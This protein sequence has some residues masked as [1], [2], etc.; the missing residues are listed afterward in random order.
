MRVRRWRRY[1]AD[2]AFVVDACG[3][4]L[5]S[6]DLT[7]G[8]VD[9]VEPE[10]DGQVRRAVQA[11]LRA[12]SDEVVVPQQH[13]SVEGLS[14]ADEQLL[15][16]WLGAPIMLG[17]PGHQSVR[18]VRSQLERLG[19]R[20][21]AV[22]HQVPLGRQG[23]SCPH[24]LVG[25]SGVFTVRRIGRVGA[26]VEVDG[27][28]LLVD[29]VASNTLRDVVFEARRIRTVLVGAT[30]CRPQVRPVLAVTG[31]VVTHRPAFGSLVVPAS[32]VGDTLRRLEPRLQPVE[33]LALSRVVR[34]ASTWWA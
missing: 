11:Y 5:G 8:Q 10:N 12:D 6:V 25:P 17:G 15:R 32:D 7:S 14:V 21:W 34:R 18:S 23:S 20:G 22:V 13:S 3:S 4:P 29:G 2:R 30:S 24:L 9:L 19:D 26:Q 31:Q 16:Q 27:S 33:Q 1:G 28:G